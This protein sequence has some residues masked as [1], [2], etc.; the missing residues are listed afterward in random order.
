MFDSSSRYYHLETAKYKGS[1]GSLVSY[2]KRRFLTQTEKIE[3]QQEVVVTE[4]QR[5]DLIAFQMYGDAE[6]FW[7]VCDANNAMNP[8]DLT[9][10]VGTKLKIASP[11]ITIDSVAN[12][13]MRPPE[14]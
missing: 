8:F 5:L 13:A 2:K 11:K 6:Q 12:Q 9:K 7:Q 1:D 3:T 4:G 10:N 14:E